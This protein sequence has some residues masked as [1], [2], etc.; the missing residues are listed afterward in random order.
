[1]RPSSEDV[2]AD[3]VFTPGTLA[4]R[5]AGNCVFLPFQRTTAPRSVEKRAASQI[6]ENVLSP[7]YR[8]QGVHGHACTVCYTPVTAGYSEPGRSA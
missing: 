5:F 7:P 2:S 4:D 1:M 3:W 6:A 8:K